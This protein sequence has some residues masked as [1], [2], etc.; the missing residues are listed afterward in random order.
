SFSV[1][2]SMAGWDTKYRETLLHINAS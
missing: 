1:K 2:R